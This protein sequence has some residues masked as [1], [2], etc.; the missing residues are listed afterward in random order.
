MILGLG[1]KGLI[2]VWSKYCSSDD[3]W[4]MCNYRKDDID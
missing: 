3:I 4:Y 1:L 2:V